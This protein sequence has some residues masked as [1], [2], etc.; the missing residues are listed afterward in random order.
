VKRII[1]AAAIAVGIVGATASVASAGEITG[2]GKQTPI[3]SRQSD[4][5]PAGAANSFCAFSGLNDEFILGLEEDA[6]RTQS[7]GADGPSQGF[8]EV[9]PGGNKGQVNSFMAKNKI[10]QS[11][12]P[13]VSCR[14]GYV[15]PEP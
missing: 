6:A 13:G 1:A 10:S 4:E 11:F 8:G 3:K 12:G 7:W 15:P 9:A 5:N 14:G 2:T